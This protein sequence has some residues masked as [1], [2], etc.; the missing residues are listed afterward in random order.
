[1]IIYRLYIRHFFSA[2]YINVDYTVPRSANLFQFHKNS[3]N[4]T[5][6]FPVDRST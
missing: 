1:M 4:R 5:A 2:D 3:L 6:L